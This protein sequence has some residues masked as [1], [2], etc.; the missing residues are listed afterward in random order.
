MEVGRVMHHG[1]KSLTP[2]RPSPATFA[3]IDNV[4]I[5]EYALSASDVAVL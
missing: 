5:Y 3:L 2:S 4:R 1:Q